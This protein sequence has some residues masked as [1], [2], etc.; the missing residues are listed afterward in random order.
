MHSIFLN[1][2]LLELNVSPKEITE[3]FRTI[4][5]DLRKYQKNED[6]GAV[7]ISETKE[8]CFLVANESLEREVIVGE[9]A[10]GRM[11]KG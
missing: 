7:F 2:N 5:N 1:N 8:K 4:V 6:D 11:E 10:L 9:S 3:L